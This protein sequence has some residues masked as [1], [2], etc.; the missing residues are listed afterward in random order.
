M[1]SDN[2][3]SFSSLPIIPNYLRNPVFPYVSSQPTPI[4]VINDNQTIALLCR[5]AD[6]P[7]ETD[8]IEFAILIPV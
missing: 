8:F 4:P 1:T 6:D 7:T 3:I 5:I 2:T